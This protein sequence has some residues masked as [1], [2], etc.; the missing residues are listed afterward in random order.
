M[1]VAELDQLSARLQALEARVRTLEAG[2]GPS[3]TA[4]PEGVTRPERPATPAAETAALAGRMALGLGGAFVF[5]SATQAGILPPWLGVVLGLT[6]GLAWLVAADR[7]ASRGRVRDA[8]ADAVMAAAIGLPLV[9]EATARFRFLDVLQAWVA[10][11]L[12]ASGYLIV[13]WRRRMPALLWPAVAGMPPLCLA[14]ALA[15]KAFPPWLVLL[16]AGA[17]LLQWVTGRDARFRP[18]GTTALVLFDLALA[19]VTGMACIA[20]P[21]VLERALV[22]WQVLASQTAAFVLG[23]ALLLVRRGDAWHAAVVTFLGL[24]GALA[25]GERTG[26]STLAV[27]GAAV[28]VG[29]SACALALRTARPARLGAPGLAIVVV[30]LAVLLRATPLVVALSALALAAALAALSGREGVGGAWLSMQAALAGGIVLTL[31][32]ALPFGLR[33]LAGGEAPPSWSAVTLALGAGLIC[34]AALPAH[35]GGATSLARSALLA[36]LVAVGGGLLAIVLGPLLP[37]LLRPSFRTGLIL[38]AAICMAGTAPSL[39][40]PLLIAGGFKILLDEL[41]AGEPTVLVISLSLYGAALLLAPRLV[42]RRRPG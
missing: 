4:T 24:G 37:P 33:A 22:P 27:G 25:V 36:A 13:A 42:R 29:L 23:A 14:L 26:A 15:T 17:T 35:G 6:Y 9:W 16:L 28:L 31:S 20:T 39:V 5:R 19:L 38:V 2:L 1:P 11:A 21:L 40:Y 3:P 34:A 8:V 7:A 10:V 32:G 18:V 30:G 41:P 12:I